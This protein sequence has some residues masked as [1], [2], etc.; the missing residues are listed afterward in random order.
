M[1]NGIPSTKLRVDQ[2]TKIFLDQ[3]C[4]HHILFH[5]ICNTSTRC[6]SNCSQS[7]EFHLWGPSVSALTKMAVWIVIG[8]PNNMILRVLN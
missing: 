8:I 7:L 2:R 1:F 6:Q 4:L 5:S 3:E